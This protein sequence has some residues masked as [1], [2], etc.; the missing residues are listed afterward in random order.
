MNNHLLNTTPIMDNIIQRGQ[1]GYKLNA[2]ELQAL[3]T[4]ATDL[5]K[6]VEQETLK[7]IAIAQKFIEDS[8]VIHRTVREPERQVFYIDVGNMPQQRIDAYLESIRDKDTLSNF[9]MPERR[10]FF[11]DVG[12]MPSHTVKECL[13]T[14][15]NMMA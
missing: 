13:A 2:S 14:I 3:M 15:R 4:H 5:C 10:V 12:E 1:A 9:K 8:V 11:V 7:S 6:Y